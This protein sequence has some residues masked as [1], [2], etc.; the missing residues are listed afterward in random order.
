M[1]TL[2]PFLRDV[3]CLPQGAFSSGTVPV[4]AKDG[5]DTGKTPSH[6][7]SVV[8]IFDVC[9]WHLSDMPM[10]TENVCLSVQTGVGCTRSE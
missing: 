1:L 4:L 9:S 5:T 6:R 8:Y 3:S 7:F 2:D 10:D